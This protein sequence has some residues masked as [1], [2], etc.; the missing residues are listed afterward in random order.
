MTKQKNSHNLIWLDLEMTGLDHFNDVIL[1]IATV[2]TDKDL[3]ILANGPNL[4]IGQSEEM[5]ARM[6]DWCTKTHTNS[7]L[8]DRVRASTISEKEAEHQTLE[9]IRQWIPEHSSP[10]CG[11]SIGTDRRFLAKY[12][13]AL[14]GYFHYRIIDVSSIKELAK[15]WRPDLKELNKHN[16][17]LAYEDV[18]DSI[19]ELRYFYSNFFIS[20]AG[21]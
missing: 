7:G 13:P 20:N 17:H 1:E 8:L 14:E 3:N 6:D 9:F 2:V 16:R 4:A 19:D 18:I 12:M 10:L 11:N 5:L 21:Q 15:R